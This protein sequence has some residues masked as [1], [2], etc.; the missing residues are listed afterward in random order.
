MVRPAAVIPRVVRPT[1]ETNTPAYFRRED[2]KGQSNHVAFSAAKRKRPP[3]P[4]GRR[5]SLGSRVERD[6]HAQRLQDPLGV[7]EETPGLVL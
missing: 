2:L 5:P 3:T 6:L 1:Q 7:V 4:G